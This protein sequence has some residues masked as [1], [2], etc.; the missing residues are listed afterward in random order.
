MRL[1]LT[2][3]PELVAEWAKP[4]VRFRFVELAQLVIEW[5]KGGQSLEYDSNTDNTL[6]LT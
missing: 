5:G 1:T 4:K 3:A 2:P 6:R